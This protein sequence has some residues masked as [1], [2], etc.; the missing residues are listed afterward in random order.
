[1]A[2]SAN[3]PFHL[4]QDTGHESWRGV[5]WD[6]WP[7]AGPVEP[8]TSVAAYR[9][10]VRQLIASGAALDEGMI[11]LDARLARSYPTVEVRVA[12]VCTDLDDTVLV[13]A[14]VRALA[15]TAARGEGPAHQWRTE[16]LRAARW[17][18]RH[19]GTSDQLLDPA[20]GALV[21]AEDALATML[22]HLA[23][24]LADS[25][26]AALVENGIERMLTHG[27]GAARQRAQVGADGDL[28]TVLDDLRRR[29]AASYRG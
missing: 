20:Y 18:A 3:S 14:V 24:A 22:D 10:T 11:Y 19:D 25:G 7:T 9:A 23:P 5:V 28:R 16:M 15:E 27:T 17:R 21:R 26:D 2:L 8:F 29:T 6:R 12:D 13:A 4:G 1:M